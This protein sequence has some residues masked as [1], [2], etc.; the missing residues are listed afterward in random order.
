MTI[1]YVM[2][3]SGAGKDS[4]LAAARTAL[5]PGERIAFAH[6]YIT[7]PRDMGNENHVALSE[8]EF[9][10]RRAAGL[11]AFD[12]QA[13]G[14]R[15]AIG[16]EIDLWQKA[17]FVVVVSG[18]REHYAGL[19]SRPDLIPV[20]ITASSGALRRRLESRGRDD[21]DAISERLGRAAQYEVDDPAAIKIDN[22]GTLE[23]S[24]RRLIELLRRAAPRE[25]ST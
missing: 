17:G 1:V 21:P 2:G 18:S 7:R 23:V 14:F 22:S 10:A 24:A 11:F 25:I 5:M 12:W 8:T 6:R 16:V 19:Q 15:Y 20:L 3:P 9:E 13:H 4:V